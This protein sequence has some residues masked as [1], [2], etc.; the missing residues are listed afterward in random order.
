MTRAH[1][2]T[3]TGP[4]LW[5][6]LA[7]LTACGAPEPPSVLLVTLDTVRADHLSVYGYPRSTTPNLEALAREA[8]VFEHAQASSAVTPVSHASI[9]TGLDPDRHGLRALHATR[10]ARLAEER[11]TLAEHLAAAGYDTAAFVSA[12]TASAHFGLDQGFATWDERFGGEASSTSEGIVDNG[13]AQRSAADVVDAAIAWLD[14]RARSRAPFLLWTHFFDAH[15]DQL[16]APAAFRLRWVAPGQSPP[17]QWRA[18]YDGDLAYID[19]QIGRLLEAIAARGHGQD[20]VVAVVGDHGEALG[21]RGWW[22]H[23]VLFQEQLRVPFLLRLPGHPGRRVTDQ[24][25]TTDLVPTLLDVLTPEA[26]PAA[27]DGRTLTGWLTDP[28]PRPLPAYSETLF[29]LQAY[30]QSP[31]RDESWL[32]INDGRWKLIVRRDRRPPHT[33][34]DLL[35]DLREDPGETT[36]Q[37]AAHPDVVARLRP[38]LERALT[39]L[40]AN[41]PDHEPALDPETI[42]KLRSLGYAGGGSSRPKSP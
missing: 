16:Q 40:P 10:L 15:D 39:T 27:M 5:L 9:L 25:R 36:D 22:G 4:L 19:H 13:A 28:A 1:R 6:T 21:E 7:S 12:F 14:T 32:A 31:W 24:V 20:L 3:A 34:T 8:Y 30:E 33:E 37:A 26:P 41:D 18:V 42:E 23:T 35:F 11:M 2:H 29:D 38:M 17:E